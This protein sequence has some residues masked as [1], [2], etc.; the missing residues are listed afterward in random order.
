MCT[1]RNW[2]RYPSVWSQVDKN[3]LFETK[4]GFWIKLSRIPTTMEWNHFSNHVKWSIK[5]EWTHRGNEM[6]FYSIYSGSA[7]SGLPIHHRHCSVCLGKHTC[8]LQTLAAHI[9]LCRTPSTILIHSCSYAW[10]IA[11]CEQEK[12]RAVCGS[13]AWCFQSG[14]CFSACL[15]YGHMQ[16]GLRRKRCNLSSA[17][18]ASY[19]TI[20]NKSVWFV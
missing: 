16:Q 20:R 18:A 12:P 3:V 1:C 14:F 19:K 11:T 9:K 4:E 7:C 10:W 13:S 15:A 17:P 5:D 2:E 8:S 6:S